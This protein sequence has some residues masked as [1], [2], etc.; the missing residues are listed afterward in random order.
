MEA[1]G[2]ISSVNSSI[3]ELLVPDAEVSAR[4]A[5]AQTLPTLEIDELTYQVMSFSIISI[6]EHYAKDNLW[7]PYELTIYTGFYPFLCISG[8]KCYQRDG[9]RPSKDS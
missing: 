1:I 7:L 2:I 6:S 4:T 8:C 3:V 5:E 9:H